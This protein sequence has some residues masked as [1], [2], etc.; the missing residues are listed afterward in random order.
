[1]S[2]AETGSSATTNSGSRTIARAIATRWRW[3]PDSSCGKRSR[4]AGEADL[5]QRLRDAL[6]AARVELS[7]GTWRSG[8]AD[9]VADAHARVER[10]IGVLEH[11]LAGAGGSRCAGR[12]PARSS[13]AKRISPPPAGISRSMARPSVVLPEPLPPTSAT[14]SP[15]RIV[16]VDA[17]DG[18][19]ARLRA[20]EEALAAAELDHEAARARSAARRRGRRLAPRAAPRQRIDQRRAC[21]AARRRS[22]ICARCPVSTSLPRLQ[23]H[24]ALRRSARP[25]RDRG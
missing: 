20:A 19:H 8:S 22:R 13:A 16:E 15:A 9:D 18:T 12:A 6:R 2:S 1:M 17:V 23:H 14:V 10:G 25:G 21:R 4:E 3:P 7:S 11:D 24:D 5:V